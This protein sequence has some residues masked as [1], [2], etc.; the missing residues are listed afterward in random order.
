M[1]STRTLILC[2]LLLAG[3]AQASTFD[4]NL[5]SDVVGLQATFPSTWGDL[6]WDVGLLHHR[7]DGDVVH[8]G[9]VLVDE[10]SAGEDLIA[11]LG[12]R[13]V[14]IDA[15]NLNGQAIALGGFFRYTFPQY[16]RIGI[17][18]SAYF[19]PDVLA[20]GDTSQYIE[21]DLRVQYNLLRRGNIYLGVR[22]VKADF[23]PLPT[24]SIDSG[25]HIGIRIEF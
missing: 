11:G 2:G 14:T 4:V 13:L 25:A 15:T 20:F 6:T 17:A 10:A 24:A 9:L 22:S 8:V 3:T 21:V 1:T 19:A 23:G 12:G 7:D 16:N 18:G 5:N